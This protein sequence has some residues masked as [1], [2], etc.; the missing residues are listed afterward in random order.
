MRDD[1]T[2]SVLYLD[3]R[4]KEKRGTGTKSKSQ[5]EHAKSF[6]ARCQGSESSSSNNNS[7]SNNG[8]CVTRG[9]HQQRVTVPASTG[10]QVAS[11]DSTR[12]KEDGDKQINGQF[13]A[14]TRKKQRTNGIGA[15]ARFNFARWCSFRSVQCRRSSWGER[16]REKRE[17]ETQRE[18]HRERQS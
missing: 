5:K 4:K 14:C 13:A 7:N 11:T 16:D 15:W 1:S 18:R 6:C 3:V 8:L 9:S 12:E 2:V 17:R 10:R